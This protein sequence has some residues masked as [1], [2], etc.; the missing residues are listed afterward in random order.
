MKKIFVLLSG[1]TMLCLA[2]GARADIPDPDVLIKN[3]V[4]EVLDIV[5][6]DKELRS[7]N[8]K[9]MLEL[10]D[11][12]VLPHFNFEHMTKLAVGKSWRTATP[13]Q[14][15][16]LMSEFRILLVRTYTK[17]FTSYRDQVVE[18]KP[19]KLD[20]AATEVT[21]KTAIV[22]PGSSQQPVLVDYDMEKMPDGWKVY[23]LTV[24]GVSLVTSYRGTFAD[25]IQQVGIDGLIKTLADKNSTAASNAALAEKADSK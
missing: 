7:G 15:K 10:V 12:K 5:R 23:D 9:K 20:P 3:T 1:V 14:K 22:K 4:H 19:F 8:Q 16:A 25:Q 11:A 18:I 6:S 21:V 13:E 2:S 17:A 24:E